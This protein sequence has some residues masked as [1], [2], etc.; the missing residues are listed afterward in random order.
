MLNT[1]TPPPRARHCLSL[2]KTQAMHV[3]RT[4]F[5]RLCISTVEVGEKIIMKYE[6]SVS[7][8]L[9]LTSGMQIAYTRR[10]QKETEL[11]K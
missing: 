8:F 4:T 9:S 3:H 2:R 7:V 11:F 6:N 10:V 1:L 5:R